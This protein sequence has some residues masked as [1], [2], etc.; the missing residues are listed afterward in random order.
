MKLDK[1]VE[2]TH[3]KES[4]RYNNGTLAIFGKIWDKQD[5]R[6]L[7][8][9]ANLLDLEGYILKSPIRIGTQTID[10]GIYGL[11]VTDQKIYED[12]DEGG[13]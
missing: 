9:I 4:F 2:G 3:N 10:L 8:E 1:I 6:T 13:E 7:I 5:I 12:S 11:H